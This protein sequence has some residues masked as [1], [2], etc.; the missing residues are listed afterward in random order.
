[1]ST[2]QI[3]SKMV[4]E[5]RF[6]FTEKA[7]EHFDAEIV[8]LAKHHCMDDHAV[9]LTSAGFDRFKEEVKSLIRRCKNM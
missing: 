6:G 2:A 1:M 3:Y 9:R 5:D 7:F 8:K 4:R